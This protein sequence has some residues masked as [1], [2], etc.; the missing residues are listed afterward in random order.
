MDE[1]YRN[2]WAAVL[3][4]AIEDAENYSAGFHREKALAW[5]E[6]KSEEPGSFQWICSALDLDPELIKLRIHLKANQMVSN[7]TVG[8]SVDEAG[9]FG[10]QG[11]N[12]SRDRVKSPLAL[13]SNPKF[14][15]ILR[16]LAYK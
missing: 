10:I 8:L 11:L 7:P 3:I 6:Q 9:I 14:L 1:S 13:L 5:F 16:P 15:E 2:L 4:Q 12:R